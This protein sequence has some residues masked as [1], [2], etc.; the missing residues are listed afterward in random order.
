MRQN[1]KRRRRKQNAGKIVALILAIIFLSFYIVYKVVQYHNTHFSKDTYIMEVDCSGL[2]IEE[3]KEKIQEQVFSKITFQVIASK[4]DGTVAK[5]EYTVNQEQMQSFEIEVSTDK[6]TE[7]LNQHSLEEIDTNDT[8]YFFVNEK[9]VQEYLSTIPELQKEKQVIPQDAYLQIGDDLQVKIVPEVYGN[10]LDFNQA[11]KLAMQSLKNGNTEIDFTV[12]TN[13]VPKVTSKDTK[14]VEKQNW[15]NTILSSSICFKLSNGETITLDKAITKD[16]LNLESM[17]QD[18]LSSR[19]EEFLQELKQQVNKAN[20]SMQFEATGIGTIK[21]GVG[22]F[23]RAQLDIEAE[24]IQLMKELQSG[25]NCERVPNY[26]KPFI[27]DLLY[28]YVELDITRQMLWL[29][30]DGICILEARVVTGNVA[31][32]H[33]TPTGIYFLMYKDRN[34]PLTG[35]NNDGSR[36]CSIVEYWMPFYPDIGFHDA[37]WR[38]NAE[39]VPTSYLHNGSHGCVNMILEDAAVLYQNINTSMPIIIYKS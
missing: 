9:K 17:E 20:S 14:L 3:A 23:V 28:D 10:E 33:V 11:C 38:S 29:Y 4:E 16:W 36:Y 25:I 24:K 5:K 13:K 35:Y 31:N 15:C 22:S 18:D 32:G 8:Q 19:I 6:L 7:I 21:I 1:R 30:K 2:T 27:S 34:V 39:Y 37:N 12:I 26:T